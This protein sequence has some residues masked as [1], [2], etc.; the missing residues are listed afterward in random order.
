MLKI[1]LLIKYICIFFITISKYLVKY[2]L[3]IFI[4]NYIHSKFIHCLSSHVIRMVFFN[5]QLIKI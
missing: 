2:S 1:Y 3:I 5:M 4:V